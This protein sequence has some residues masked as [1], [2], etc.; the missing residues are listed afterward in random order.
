MKERCAVQK[1][2]KLSGSEEKSECGKDVSGKDEKA[3]CRK[4]V[5]E[6]CSLEMRRIHSEK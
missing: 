1:K 2:M 5:T 4:E 3:G 6:Q